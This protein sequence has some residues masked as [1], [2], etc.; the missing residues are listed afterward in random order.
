[1]ETKERLKGKITVKNSEG[2]ERE[3]ARGEEKR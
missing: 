3:S 1:M 2:R